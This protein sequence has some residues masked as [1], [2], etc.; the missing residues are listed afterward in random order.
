MHLHVDQ[1]A[2]AADLS[3][4]AQAAFNFPEQCLEDEFH[5]IHDAAF[6]VMHRVHMIDATRLWARTRDRA[7]G[8]IAAGYAAHAGQSDH[9]LIAFLQVKGYS[10]TRVA[11]SYLEN[12]GDSG[13]AYFVC[14]K[15]AG[16]DQGRLE[17]H[18]QKLGIHF[19][20]DSILVIPCGGIGASLLG[21]TRRAEAVPGFGERLPV[22][23]NQ[24]TAA[25]RLLTLLQGREL[26]RE[27]VPRPGTRH[28][29]WAQHVLVRDLERRWQSAEAVK[30]AR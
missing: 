3:R 6:A 23:A 7:C 26:P 8:A 17:A 19:D 15:G 24:P 5:W 18:L 14:S 28:G 9:E 1:Y 27:E 25:G 29:Q 13:F 2:S 21:T 16:E 30:L 22:D 12:S 11:A 4:G 20:R 10:I